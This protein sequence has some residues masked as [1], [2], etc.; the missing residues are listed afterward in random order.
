MSY[1]GWLLAAMTA[2]ALAWVSFRKTPDATATF[3]LSIL[4]PENTS[5]E[6]FAISP[7]GR[8][9][10]FTADWKG[11]PVLWVRPLGSLDAKPWREPN[12][13]LSRSGRLTDTVLHSSHVPN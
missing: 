3:R 7:D 11:S 10:A 9:V 5:F 6:S 4:P 13:P 12:Q 1:A 2:L 8:T